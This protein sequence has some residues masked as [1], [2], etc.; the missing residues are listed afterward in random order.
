[1]TRSI[2][3]S[4]TLGTLL[5]APQADARPQVGAAL[6]ATMSD[7]QAA[8]RALTLLE[9]RADDLGLTNVREE[10]SLRSVTRDPL[11]QFHVR[12]DQQIR[13]IPVFG[14]Q[15]I[16][17]M[18][19]RGTFRGVTDAL[20]PVTGLPSLRAK[21]SPFGA[22][23]TA[24]ADFARGTSAHPDIELTLF[25]DRDGDLFLTYRV[26]LTDIE[27]EDPK[28]HVYFISAHTGRV[29]FD[30]NN[31]HTRAA[32]GTGESLYLGEVPLS[33]D[34]DGLSFEMLDSTRGG[35]YTT[36]MGNG[37]SGNGSIFTDSDNAWGNGTERDRASAAA[38]AH[39]GTMAT[40]DFFMERFDRNGIRDDGVGSLSRVHYGNNYNNAFW[41]DSCFCMT[42][43]D[44]DGSV[45]SP[46]V[47]IDVIAHEMSHGVT[48]ATSGLV[49][50]W[51]AG[52][53]NEAFSDI[54]GTAVEFY[55]ADQGIDSD[56]DFYIGEDIYTPGTPGDALRYMDD[57][58][59]DGRSI[60]HASQMR[61]FTDPHYSS[62][63]PNYVFY[64][65]AQGGTH[66]SSGDTVSGAI[67]V[68][69]AA[70]VFYYGMTNYMTSRS[71]FSSQKDATVRAA[72]EIYGT[73]VA[74]TVEAAWAACG[75]N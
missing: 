74:N 14:S 66:V 35:I 30:H 52:G 71:R 67:G 24:L 9:A 56:P 5:L 46:L 40:W 69:R 34:Q 57:P 43:G 29:I 70:A 63:L 72:R 26:S 22:L 4:A 50:F 31:L 39:Y 23:K 61:F 37:T 1:M 8:A 11:G 48:S 38:D 7:G 54:M 36:D 44:G 75:V 73:A 2:L 53:M 60:V 21:I 13:G 42:Y 58:S 68:E 3:L 33:T 17:H 27:S 62:G 41:S 20:T 19:G 15:I 47:S 10:L 12:L 51:D 45:L 28:E 32:E 6:Q 16:V 25:E 59:K 55:A 65:A 18:D 64:L 49:Y